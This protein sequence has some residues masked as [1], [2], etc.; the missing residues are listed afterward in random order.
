M[1]RM[2]TNVETKSSQSR[3]RQPEQT[4][5]CPLSVIKAVAPTFTQLEAV[6]SRKINTTCPFQTNNQLI[7][8]HTTLAAAREKLAPVIARNVCPS[9]PSEFTT[10]QWVRGTFELT[11]LL[12]E[13][14]RKVYRGGPS[15]SAK[16]RQDLLHGDAN[17]PTLVRRVSEYH[18][19]LIVEARTSPMS[20]LRSPNS[21]YSCSS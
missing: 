8:I 14:T 17:I 12:E 18:Q 11:R 10:Q 16:L 13:R 3:N 1:N 6:L 20:E 5:P 21:T 7:D 2:S 9:Q 19:R 4:T 15:D